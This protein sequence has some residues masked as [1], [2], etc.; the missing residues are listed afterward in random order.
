MSDAVVFTNILAYSAQVACIAVLGGVTALA[1]RRW[2]ARLRYAY[3]R[4]LV[5]LCALLPWLQARR[6]LPPDAAG[7]VTSVIESID[8]SR[9]AA[10]A[11]SLDWTTAAVALLAAGAALRLAWLGVGLLYL[12]RLR[13][14]G[15]PAAAIEDQEALQHA[16]GTRA[17][18]RYVARLAQPATFGLRRP[19]VLLPEALKRHSE[20]VQRAVL[21]HELLHVRR[22]DWPWML[23]EELLRAVLWFHPGAWWLISRV[24]LARE[25]LVD[26]LVVLATG[27]RRAYME[28]LLAFAEAPGAGG[29]WRRAAIAPVAAF[30]RRRHLF[31]R[32]V[33]I[34]KEAVMSSRQIVLWSVAA[35][36]VMSGATWFV[37]GAFPLQQPIQAGR[38]QAPGSTGVTIASGDAPGPLEQRARP[39]TPENPIPRRTYSVSPQY[40]AGAVPAGARGGVSVRITL[41]ETGRVAEVRPLR[42]PER[43]TF[44]ITPQGGPGGRGVSE[45]NRA[46]SAVADAF[47][48]AAARAVRQWQYDPPAD[49]PISFQVTFYFQPDADASLI[50]H[51]GPATAV[52]GGG[53]AG[54]TRLVSPAGAMSAP[55]PP[56]PPPAPGA[57]AD[58]AVRVGGVIMAPTRTKNVAPVYPAVAQAAKVQGV[59]IVE[60]RIEPDGRVGDVRVVRSI[61][62][63]DQAA[64][65]A[66]RQWEYTP[67]LLNG[68][69]VAIIMTMTVNFTLT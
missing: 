15:E 27:R 52:G 46:S 9:V 37:V 20:H 61:P 55:P 65:D 51:G 26:E 25:E 4:A 22:R 54:V 38:A 17:E 2:P 16:L 53:R 57:W 67:T 12:R 68:V 45:T 24:Q 49:G 62:L 29:G 21:Y 18:V 5:A 63:L 8:T 60:A 3:W 42:A 28:A 59:V 43:V 58:G 69:P 7:G 39:I 35:G 41:D 10:A 50:A 11:P 64:I 66:V 32:I 44:D 31:H 36:L 40:P 19:V 1:A 47:T 30:A 13:T 33:L 23:V 34:S 14:A 6:A 56:P 48:D